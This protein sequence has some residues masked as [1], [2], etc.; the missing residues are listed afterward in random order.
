MIRF[1]WRT[2]LING[3]RDKNMA[4]FFSPKIIFRHENEPSE[5]PQP[6]GFGNA[7]SGFFQNFAM[8]RLNG[9]FT[10]INAAAW[11]LYVDDLCDLRSQ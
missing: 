4:Y 7:P 5:S 6:K 8:Q 3:P 10:G 11:Q 2:Y 9:A 1:H